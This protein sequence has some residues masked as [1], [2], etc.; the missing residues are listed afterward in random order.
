L[1]PGDSCATIR[2]HDDGHVL[3]CPERDVRLSVSL[4][5]AGGVVSLIGRFVRASR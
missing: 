2:R 1:H 4:R 5:H 3:A